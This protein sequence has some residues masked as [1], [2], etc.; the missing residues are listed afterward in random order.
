MNVEKKERSEEV[1]SGNEATS[2]EKEVEKKENVE[3][4]G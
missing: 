4:V 1:A 3:D 2:D